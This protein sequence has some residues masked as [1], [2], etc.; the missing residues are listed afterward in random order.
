MTLSCPFILKRGVYVGR[1]SGHGVCRIRCSS[2]FAFG[3]LC[4]SRLALGYGL[5]GGK[6][7]AGIVYRALPA[8][9]DFKGD[10]PARRLR[11]RIKPVAG[12]IVVSTQIRLA[13]VLVG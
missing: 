8:C 12:R 9:E 6:S 10:G 2:Q 5:R 7:V 11:L 3:S 1:E 4:V 13:Q